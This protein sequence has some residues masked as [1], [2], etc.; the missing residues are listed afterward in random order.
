MVRRW[1]IWICLVSAE[2]GFALD[3]RYLVG[4]ELK[5][6]AVAQ[7]SIRNGRGLGLS[8]EV[9]IG[10]NSF[11]TL[12]GEKAFGDHQIAADVHAIETS[13]AGLGLR[14]YSYYRTDSLYVGADLRL[15]RAQFTQNFEQRP[16]LQRDYAQMRFE[17]GFRWLWESG[18]MLRLGAEFSRQIR[19][20]ERQEAPADE[21]LALRQNRYAASVLQSLR[22][23]GHSSWNP[24]VDLGLGFL[25]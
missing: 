1:L 20:F 13:G 4:L 17:G 12:A 24:G 23:I 5:P 2:R 6:L 21:A 22:T 8:S 11:A 14:H 16:W 25:F 19:E 9:F 15:L 10:G 7:N 3:V 18:F